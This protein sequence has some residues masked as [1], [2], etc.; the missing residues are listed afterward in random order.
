MIEFQP[1]TAFDCGVLFSNLRA[2]DRAEMEAA[3]PD[4]TAM[5]LWDACKAPHEATAAFHDGE[6]ICIFGVSAHPVYA[7]IGIPWLLGTPLLDGFMLHVCK[8]GRKYV[9]EWL[10][11]YTV[12]T[13]LTDKRNRRIILWLRWL[14]FKF[15]PEEVP[16]GPNAIPFI[17]FFKVQPCVTPSASPW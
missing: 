2:H 15:A 16:M 3:H 11:R 10:Q 8:L 12:L 17:Q 14:G 4:L 9:A 1:A 13:N 6:L 7:D 5:D